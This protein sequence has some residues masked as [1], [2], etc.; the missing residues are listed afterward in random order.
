[1]FDSQLSFLPR[2]DSEE[3]SGD[4]SISDGGHSIGMRSHQGINIV[5]T[6]GIYSPSWEFGVWYSCLFI[7]LLI[8]E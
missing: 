7:I 1:M 6:A 5:S 4:V 3:V 8:M 2:G